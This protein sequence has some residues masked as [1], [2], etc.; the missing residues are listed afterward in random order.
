MALIKSQRSRAKL[1][2]LNSR[3]TALWANRLL[4][5]GVRESQLCTWELLVKNHTQ[6]SIFGMSDHEGVFK[7]ARQINK[8]R[9]LVLTLSNTRNAHSNHRNLDVSSPM[10]LSRLPAVFIR[11]YIYNLQGLALNLIL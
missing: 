8:Q 1:L 3:C 2:I 7:P 6:R 5:V 10:T 9:I 4:E 11:L